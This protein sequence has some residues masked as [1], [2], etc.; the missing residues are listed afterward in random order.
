MEPLP[1]LMGTVDACSLN[2]SFSQIG[3]AVNVLVR[4][5]DS[6]HSIMKQL[7]NGKKKSAAC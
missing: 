7:L 2:Q 5:M 3:P 4:I 6:D 1:R